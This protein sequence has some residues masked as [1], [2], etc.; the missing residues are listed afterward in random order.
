MGAVIKM[1]QECVEG[2]VRPEA[3][4]N[5]KSYTMTAFAAIGDS[6]FWNTLKPFCITLSLIFAYQ[7]RVWACLVF[8]ILYNTVHLVL[9]GWGFWIGFEEGIGMIDR[10]ARWQLPRWTGWLKGVLP[11][12][13]GVL[14]S[15]AI[16]FD[17]ERM[18]NFYSFMVLPIA[19]I[20]YLLI[21]RNISPVAILFGIFMV[22]VVAIY[23]LG[24]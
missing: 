6:F 15:R 4:S 20:S 3:V 14:L 7:S 9:R 22:A 5:F 8:L 18:A 17:S 19:L 10:I 11:V 12:F 2:R 1:E 16:F 24:R 21:R 13:L 23:T